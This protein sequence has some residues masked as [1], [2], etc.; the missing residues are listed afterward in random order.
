MKYY[1]ETIKDN[2][3]VQEEVTPENGMA[4]FMNEPEEVTEAIKG[5]F[6]N[7]TEM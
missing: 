4:L 6:D 7:G 5:V 3:E 1:D 2:V